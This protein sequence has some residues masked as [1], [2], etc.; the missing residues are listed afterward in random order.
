ML[1]AALRDTD[2]DI[3]GAA[4]D[5]LGRL[6]DRRAADALIKCL[7]DEDYYV[8]AATAEALGEL[9]DKRALEALAKALKDDDDHVVKKFIHALAEIGDERAL[10]AAA[11]AARR[12]VDPDSETQLHIDV[13][14]SLAKLGGA[15]A[16]P[17]LIEMFDCSSRNVRS[18]SL[19]TIL[20]FGEAAAAPL[21]EA[22]KSDKPRIRACA[23]KG[24]AML[25]EEKGFKLL[26]EALKH[27]SW[28]VRAT[29]AESL[30]L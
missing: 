23:L 6:G 15:K 12:V 2:E 14:N 28:L 24:L 1:L 17:H 20:R 8:R 4:A 5:A 16:V 18:S 9:G 13:L 10:T 26:L 22:A 27:K 3:R 19:R 30:S 29:A 11:V 21:L 25:R 7:T